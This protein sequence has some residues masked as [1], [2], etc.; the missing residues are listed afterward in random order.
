[1]NWEEYLLRA[2]WGDAD[3]IFE[4]GVSFFEGKNGKTQDYVESAK[5]FKLAAD[6]G[7]ME[8]KS[9]LAWQY[10]TGN[11]IDRN[12]QLSFN[13]FLEAAEHGIAFAQYWIA[14]LY[15]R[16]DEVVEVDYRKGMKWARKA[17]NNGMAPAANNLIFIYKIRMAEL[18]IS[19]DA[20][21]QEDAPKVRHNGDATNET[22]TSTPT[23]LILAADCDDCVWENTPKQKILMEFSIDYAVKYGIKRVAITTTERLKEKAL[24]Y[25]ARKGRECSISTTVVTVEDRYNGS[26]N[27]LLEAEKKIDSEKVIVVSADCYYG[28]K[29]FN[30]AL[31][32]LK[33]G[34]PSCTI[35]YEFTYKLTSKYNSFQSYP[36]RPRPT[37]TVHIKNLS[38]K[39]YT[40]DIYARTIYLDWR[41][42]R[43]MFAFTAN[44]IGLLK[45]EYRCKE[46]KY[47]LTECI[48]ALMTKNTEFPLTSI[49]LD[50]RKDLFRTNNRKQA[51][52]IYTAKDG[53]LS[54]CAT[55]ETFCDFS[56]LYLYKTTSST[57]AFNFE[58]YS[59]YANDYSPAL[60][61][62]YLDKPFDT[63]INIENFDKDFHLGKTD[64]TWRDT[65]LIETDAKLSIAIQNGIIRISYRGDR[66]EHVIGEKYPFCSNVEFSKCLKVKEF[67]T[68]ADEMTSRTPMQVA[69]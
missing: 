40:Y 61:S 54:L 48:G 11:G 25:M 37:T 31:K 14:G 36:V 1:M 50:T 55:S 32:A 64:L 43:N 6:K 22:H 18:G 41:S 63:G 35:G 34:N 3:A 7:H 30:E 53:G 42:S 60:S 2:K 4:I 17:Y 45:N 21:L 67:K 10:G 66:T 69:K 44:T 33:A 39:E 65:G 12:P 5:W 13:L 20:D 62:Y 26:L 9:Y 47:D 16:G 49:K 19:E 52:N 8:A 59:L 38:S 57:L 51:K 15:G 46:I 24:A 27:Q 28:E 68:I 56:I 58:A 23:L 29:L